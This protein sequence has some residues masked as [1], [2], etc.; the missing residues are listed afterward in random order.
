MKVAL[1]GLPGSGKTTL[2]NALADK[3]VD[4]HPGVPG[5]P[6]HVSV[7]PVR[8]ER[9]DWLRDLFRPKKA[10]P[11]TLTVEDHAGIPEGSA[12]LDRRGELFGRMRTA[13][14]LIIVVNAFGG[15]AAE[16][17]ELVALEL[18][19]AD[20]AICER[21]LGK[22]EQE[23]KN[24]KERDRV[25][26]ERA[27]V[28]HVAQAIREG[29]CAHGLE[30]RSE[31][32]PFIKGFQLFVRKPV[33]LF[34]NLT[35][36]SEVPDLDTAA[37]DVKHR[38]S[39]RARLEAELA[40]FRGEERDLFAAEYGIEEPL[41]ERFTRACYRGLGLITFFT[42]VGDEVRA[43]A[44]REGDDALTAAGR[45]HTDLAHGF[46]RAEVTAFEDLRALGSMREVKANGKQR[47]EGREYPVQDG[48]ILNIRFST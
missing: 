24:I 33:V 23:W 28:E 46:I 13:D 48:E 25:L 14:G 47:L 9:L 39:A 27:A 26:R 11:A 36:G 41:R 31:D 17:L 7:L 20:L 44:L 4:V 40:T 22:L 45:I 6:P 3:P 1:V 2:F 37:L 18:L 10:T 21:R 32:E 16:E 29:R 43:W 34:A 38:F 42:V 12:R 30:V 35:A 5:A 19:S 15:D 8:D